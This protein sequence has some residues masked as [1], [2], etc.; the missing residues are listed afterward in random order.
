MPGG[1][2]LKGAV[3]QRLTVR[4]VDPSM[5]VDMQEDLEAGS[6]NGDVS[7]NDPAFLTRR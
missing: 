5:V 3:L 6:T 1:Y 2:E 4:V 7:P